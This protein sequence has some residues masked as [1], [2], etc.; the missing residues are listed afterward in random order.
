MS[1]ALRRGAGRLSFAG[2]ETR[3]LHLP[4]ADPRGDC[5][6]ADVVEAA[7]EA[8][9]NGI[10]LTA[11]ENGFVCW[12]VPSRGRPPEPWPEQAAG[13]MRHLL[14]DLCAAASHAGLTVYGV[15]SLLCHGESPR[16]LPR[17]LRRWLAETDESGG[18]TALPPHLCSSRAEVSRYLGNMLVELVGAY[19]LDGI[20]LKSYARPGQFE[21]PARALCRCAACCAAVD[22]ALLFDLRKMVV[23]PADDRYRRWA[24]WQVARLGVFLEGLISRTAAVRR[25]L[26]VVLDVPPEAESNAAMRE[27]LEQGLAHGAIHHGAPADAASNHAPLRLLA[28]DV[29]SADEPA[30][31]ADRMVTAHSDG[32]FVR[33]PSWPDPAALSL[34]RPVFANPAIPAERDPLAAVMQLLDSAG[35]DARRGAQAGV[36]RHVREVLDSAHARLPGML[37]DLASDCEHAGLSADDDLKEVAD[38]ATRL[39][40]LAALL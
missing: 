8:G 21:A 37:A 18:Q 11:Y 12:N 20:I 1:D 25:G 33:S 6:V 17:W 26:R 36:L 5:T 39:L 9:F 38:A 40:Q 30:G 13:R 15:V 28:C 34:F 29:P 3:I 24:E 14:S 22:Q 23:A 32:V 7:A 31:L 19:P 35:L 10:A 4:M 27:W 2:I 16:A